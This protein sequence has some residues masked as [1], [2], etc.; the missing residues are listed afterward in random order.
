[1]PL[2]NSIV[3]IGPAGGGVPKGAGFLITPRHVL[4]CAHVVNACFGPDLYSQQLPTQAVAVVFLGQKANK[5]VNASVKEEAHWVAPLPKGASSEEPDD[6]AVLTLD[7]DS[8]S[9]ATKAPLR[10]YSELPGRTFRTSGFP[11]GWGKGQAKSGKVAGLIAGRY[12][13][14]PDDNS[15]DFVREGFSGAPIISRSHI[16]QAEVVIGMVVAARENEEDKTAYMTPAEQLLE[17]LGRVKHKDLDVDYGIVD[18][19]PHIKLVRTYLKETVLDFRS[20]PGFDLRVK[21][22]SSA[23]EIAQLFRQEPLKGYEDCAA[24]PQKVLEDA[25]FSM[26]LLQSPGGAGKSNFLAD[27]VENA[28]AQDMVPFVLDAR[29]G[30]QQE[31]AAWSPT[32]LM[33][34]LSVGAGNATFEKLP[35]KRILL[36]LDR[37]NENPQQAKGILDAV[38]KLAQGDKAGLHVVVADRLNERSSDIRPLVR[39]TMVPLPLSELSKQLKRLTEESEAKLL[40]IPFFLGMQLRR[41]PGSGATLTRAQMFKEFFRVHAKVNEYLLPGLSEAAFQAYDTFRNTA[42][43]AKEW[44]KGLEKHQF[45]EQAIGDI[46]SG[47]MLG[48]TR[49]KPKEDKEDVVEFRHQ[50][51]HDFLAGNHLALGGDKLWLEPAFNVATLDA[52]SFEA[53]EFAAELLGSSPGNAPPSDALESSVGPGS[54]TD[55]FLIKVYDWNWRA[56][57]ECVRNLDAGLNGGENPVSPDF[58]DALYCLNTVRLFDRF[59]HTRARAQSILAGIQPTFHIDLSSAKDFD[60]LRDKVKNFYKP[61]VKYYQEWK[62]LFLLET[63]PAS[64]ADLDPLWKDP[65]ISWTASNVFRKLH[66]S[67]EVSAFLQSF[68]KAIRNT[69]VDSPEGHGARWR[70]VHLM[71]VMD[72]DPTYKFLWSVTKDPGE[73]KWVRTGA[74]RSY[75]EIATRAKLEVRQHMLHQLAEWVRTTEGIPGP[76]ADQ[77][78]GIRPADESLPDGWHSDS[79]EV[80]RAGVQRATADNNLEYKQLWEEKLKEIEEL[81]KVK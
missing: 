68:Y 23:A 49:E 32:N 57:L 5:A 64:V 20:G 24:T 13:L 12:Q 80:L 43:P 51:L 79:L 50:L 56:V 45:S 55:R 33:G 8:P 2:D 74:V 81:T 62:D 63:A 4:T 42:I 28:V 48:Y 71:G 29:R 59:H 52:Q 73:N 53:L 65:F 61:K 9:K 58:K 41:G 66:P 22:V 1:M 16:S 17:V 75:I 69:A 60:D 72:D 26:L 54:R 10:M 14:V 7:K 44:E 78:M 46:V 76:V 18:E 35:P 27:L 15:T 70:I 47:A 6:I 39:A 38:C 25:E 34:I 3:A 19:F 36:L 21:R 11:A 30:T 77:I 37:L 31:A 40:A 67:A